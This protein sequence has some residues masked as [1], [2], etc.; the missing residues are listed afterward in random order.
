[1]LSWCPP[2]QAPPL[3]STEGALTADP[4]A[5]SWEAP[6]RLV[7]SAQTAPR[8]ILI[9]NLQ[10][11]YSRETASFC[12]WGRLTNSPKQPLPPCKSQGACYVVHRHPAKGPQPVSKLSFHKEALVG[13][14]SHSPDPRSSEKVDGVA[15]TQA[16]APLTAPGLSGKIRNLSLVLGD[17]ALMI[18]L[19]HK[20]QVS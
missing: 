8:A 17:A 15:R 16:P 6:P 3:C 12:Q 20:K 18:L 2:P 9:K 1:M 4:E 19:G 11:N 14:P 13:S 10:V 5:A 7:V